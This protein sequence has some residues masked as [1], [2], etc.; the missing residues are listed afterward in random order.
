MPFTESYR[1]E[2]I[3]YENV[4]ADLEKLRRLRTEPNN[5]KIIREIIESVISD[6]QIL[7]LIFK[8]LGELYAETQNYYNDAI[9]RIEA[10]NA[11]LESYEASTDEKITAL[12]DYIETIPTLPPVTAADNNKVLTVVNGSWEKSALPLYPG[13]ST[14]IPDARGV[15]F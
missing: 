3:Y 8:N 6:N 11:K 7:I 5:E 15:N 12:Y 13:S 10:L 4:V 9:T 2:K 14:F 1:L